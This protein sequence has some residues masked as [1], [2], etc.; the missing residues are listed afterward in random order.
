MESLKQDLAVASRLG[1]EWNPDFATP[2]TKSR[3]GQNV[4][5]WAQADSDV[6]IPRDTDDILS[7]FFGE[8]FDDAGPFLYQAMPIRQFCLPADI[9]ILAAGNDARIQ[10]QMVLL[11]ER[12]DDGLRKDA[13]GTCR[14]NLHDGA[15]TASDLFK[16]LRKKRYHVESQSTRGAAATATSNNQRTTHEA[17]ADRRL[18]SVG[19][20]LYGFYSVV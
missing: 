4:P 9:S 6:D 16:S 2:Q 12:N 15:L 19:S 13:K 14:R 8:V 20:T 10:R 5:F 11:D 7:Q 18:M 17:D 1:Y 3:N